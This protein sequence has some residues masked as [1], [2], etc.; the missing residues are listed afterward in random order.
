M[1]EITNMQ[2]A[3][4]ALDAGDI[5]QDQFD[6][7]QQQFATKTSD[8]NT[9]A[10]SMG[11]PSG[12]PLVAGPVDTIKDFFTGVPKAVGNFIGGATDK[13]LP[14]GQFNENVG[15]LAPSFDSASKATL[16]T[17]KHLKAVLMLQVLQKLVKK[18][19]LI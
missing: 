14:A 1:A 9:I 2:E 13:V 8:P 11:L 5:S 12:S 15:S 17:K 19:Y 7:Y 16:D 18:L 6:T 10:T 3:N 4:D